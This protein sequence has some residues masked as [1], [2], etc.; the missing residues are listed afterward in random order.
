MQK[1]KPTVFT[2]T[3]EEVRGIAAA[4]YP[5]GII[6]TNKQVKEILSCVACDEFLAKD[7]QS[8]IESLII[9]VVHEN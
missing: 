9:E 3:E 2:I 7:I 6:L 8:C 5:R 1:I 4:A